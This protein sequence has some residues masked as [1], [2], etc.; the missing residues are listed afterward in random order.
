MRLQREERSLMTAYGVL[1]QAAV[2]EEGLHAREAGNVLALVKDDPGQNLADP[3]H[4]LQAGEAPGIV[5]FGRAGNLE[6]DLA[7]ELVVV[8][9][10]GRIQLASFAPAARE[11]TS[12]AKP[13][14]Y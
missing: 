5:A 3:G 7:Q 4:R 10:Q 1:D 9:N 14:A 13:P 8:S 12:P 6:F 2:P 11:A